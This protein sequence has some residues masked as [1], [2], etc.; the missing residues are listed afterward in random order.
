MNKRNYI[1]TLM[2]RGTCRKQNYNGNLWRGTS[3]CAKICYKIVGSTSSQRGLQVHY[4]ELCIIPMTMPSNPQ[5]PGQTYFNA[6]LKCGLFGMLWGRK[7]DRVYLKNI[8]IKGWLTHSFTKSRNINRQHLCSFWKLGFP[9]GYWHTNMH[10]LSTFVGFVITMW[11]L[12]IT[13]DLPVRTAT[14]GHFHMK[15]VT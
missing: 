9:A 4:T 10:Q 11:T 7:I 6:A 15:Y 8:A 2:K 3:Q 12:E 1:A 5:Q 13:S 14:Y